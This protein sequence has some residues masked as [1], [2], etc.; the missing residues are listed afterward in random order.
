MNGSGLAEHLYYSPASVLRTYPAVHLRQACN[1]VY[2][3]GSLTQP[4]PLSFFTNHDNALK[5][6]LSEA[7]VNSQ[8]KLHLLVSQ[9]LL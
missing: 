5:N 6:K 4:V 1:K 3:N 2:P 7:E 8:L 9:A